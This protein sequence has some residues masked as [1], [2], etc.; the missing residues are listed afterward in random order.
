MKTVRTAAAVYA[1][2]DFPDGVE[3]NPQTL[4]WFQ[5]CFDLSISSQMAEFIEELHFG[6]KKDSVDNIWILKRYRG[7]QSVDYPITA[8]LSCAI[9]H[10]QSSPRLACKYLTK[11]LLYQGKK[12]DLRYYVVVRSLVPLKLVRHKLF[13]LRIA[14]EQFSLNDFESYQKHFTL[15]SNLGSSNDESDPFSIENIRGVGSRDDPFMDV[16]IESFNRENSFFTWQEHIQPKIDLVLRNIFEAVRDTYQY[17][18]I[19][20]SGEKLHPNSG[21]SLDQPN[22]CPAKAMYG[23]DIILEKFD[24]KT[25]CPKVLEVQWAP[26]CDRAIK[27]CPNFWDDILLSLYFEENGSSFYNI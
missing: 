16:F 9:R 11:P 5:Q 1:K 17:E 21:W 7:R 14:N 24:D 27:F 25:I 12:F 8:D 3:K 20:P 18:P 15:M 19:H 2:R 4:P 26:D 10:Q 23:V 13:I 6:H 22:I